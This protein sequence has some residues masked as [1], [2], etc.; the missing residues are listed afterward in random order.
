MTADHALELLRTLLQTVAMIAGPML[1]AALIAGVAIGIIQTATQ[2]NEPA[3]GYVFKVGA[4][5]IVLL[6]LGPAILNHIVGY[7]KRC[8]EAVAEVTR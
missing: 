2:V 3:V 5:V 4:L 7:T 8:L 6:T 1:L